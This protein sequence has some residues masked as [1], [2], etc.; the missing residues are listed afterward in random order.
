MF[1][2]WV[3]PEDKGITRI[4]VLPKVAAKIDTSILVMPLSKGLT[5][6]KAPLEMQNRKKQQEGILCFV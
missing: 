3:R 6:H 4:R 5:K 1:E 2:W